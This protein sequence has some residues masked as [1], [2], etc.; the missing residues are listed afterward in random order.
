MKDPKY[1]QLNLSLNGSL[2]GGIY[3][4]SKNLNHSQRGAQSSRTLLDLFEI[5]KPSKRKRVARG[6]GLKYDPELT[7]TCREKLESMK[8][9]SLASGVNVFWN[10]RLKSTAGLAYH[11]SIRIDLNTRLQRFYPEEPKRTL[12]HE[13]AHLIANH[14]ASGSRIQPHGIEWQRACSEL[15]IPGEKRCHDL[16]LA[17]TEVKKKLA[18]RCRYCGVIVPRVKRLTRESACYPCCQTHNRG[19]YSRRFLLEKISITEA[20]TLAPQYNWA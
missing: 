13:L 9:F 8:L 12:L 16:P 11:D 19:N 5:T 17:T 7:H 18:Y 4:K 1:Q 10:L 15:G 6:K 3:K 2:F 20:K 14:R